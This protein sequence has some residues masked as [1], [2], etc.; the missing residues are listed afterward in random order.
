MT[1]GKAAGSFNTF[2]IANAFHVFFVMKLLFNVV[3][4]SWWLVLLIAPDFAR[5]A[6]LLALRQKRSDLPFAHAGR[7]KREKN[8][9]SAMT[10]AFPMTGAFWFTRGPASHPP[11]QS[12]HVATR[13]PARG[14]SC[15]ANSPP[16]RRR[17]CPPGGAQQ[18]YGALWSPDD[19]WVA[20]NALIGKSWEVA[21][22]HPDGTAFRVLTAQ[23]DPKA[24]EYSLAGWNLHDKAILAQNLA[25]MVQID[26]ETSKVAWQRPVKELT[27]EEEPA[28]ALRCTISADG[29][30]LLATRY[31]ET[32]E[33]KNLDGPS[34]YLVWADIPGGAPRRLTPSKFDAAEP[35]LDPGGG[36]VLLRGFGER[37]VKTTSSD[38]LKSK[39]RIYRCELPSGKL[40]PLI[41]GRQF[42][43]GNPP[44]MSAILRWESRDSSSK[45]AGGGV[46]TFF[47]AG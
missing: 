13:V 37:D 25:V 47:R 42:T 31:V 17:F 4:L 23:S 14:S 40:T 18:A 35:W 46:T 16:A 5:A 39:T 29:K 32:D 22:I 3:G 28:G 34:S 20:F 43:H 24:E 21:A 9:G 26:P 10:L 41:E 8:R 30:F 33:F 38:G 12:I 2:L 15:C 1:L 6:P 7:K 19:D 36:F 27:G 11:G 45:I 44:E